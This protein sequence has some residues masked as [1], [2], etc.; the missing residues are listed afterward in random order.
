LISCVFSLKAQKVEISGNSPEYAGQVLKFH[1]A[2]NYINNWEVTLGE[3]TVAPNG[4][5]RVELNVTTTRLV[6]LYLGIFKA[7]FIVEPGHSY[8]VSLPPRTDKE[9]AEEESPFFEEV[10]VY[11]YIESTK[12]KNGNIIPKEEELNMRI[13]LFDEAYNPLYDQMAMDGM[14]KKVI[15]VDSTI[16][17]F[18]TKHMHTENS[19]YKDYVKYRSGMLYYATQ[20]IGVKYIS[21]TF[22]SD[23]PLLYDNEAYMDL[24]NITYNNYFMYFGRTEEGKVIYDVVNTGKDFSGLK[25][26]LQKDGTVPGDSLCELV[27][28]K[29]IYDEFYSDR[30]SRPALLTILESLIDQTRIEE[31]KKIGNQLRS[32]IT[33][34]LRGF[35]PPDFSLYNQDSTLVSLDTYKGKYIYLM[36]CTTQN[37]ACFNQY[38]LLKE[39]YKTHG[40]WLQIVVISADDHFENMRNF[41]QKNDYQWDFLYIGNQPDILKEYDVRIYPTYYLI[42]PDGKLVMSPA[43]DASQNI[44]WVFYLE[45]NNKGLWNEYI[46]KGW[47]EDKKRTDSRFELNLDRPN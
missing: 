30:F 45:L 1:S 13:I 6:Y 37:Y 8:I 19:Y 16:Q 20:Q 33:R 25:Q 44:E 31:H 39:L 9:P 2:D 28:L 35:A 38:E 34:L 23:Q 46:Q 36:F 40:K 4:D 12:D 43:P 29:N 10:T 26:L 3:C 7:R 11:L 24:F 41:R 21:K 47:I 5:F 42:G 18:T 32:K 27:I 14:R 15:K 22:F 17:A